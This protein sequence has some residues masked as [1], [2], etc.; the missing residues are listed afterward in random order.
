VKICS[1]EKISLPSFRRFGSG[2]TTNGAMGKWIARLDSAHQ[3]G[4]E[5]TFQSILIL[6]E[7]GGTG[8]RINLPAFFTLRNWDR[9]CLYLNN[10]RSHGQIDVTGGFSAS[11]R[12]RNIL[13]S[14]SDSRLVML[15]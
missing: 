8:G 9:F 6:V 14:L 11:K 12:S 10:Q 4:P 5:I 1:G 2:A 13:G 3:I 15:Y 7:S